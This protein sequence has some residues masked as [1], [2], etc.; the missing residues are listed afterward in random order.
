MSAVVCGAV[1]CASTVWFGNITYRTHSMFV[2]ISG[3][4]ELYPV[5]NFLKKEVACW[6]LL[7][8]RPFDV[9]RNAISE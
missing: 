3:D 1:M 6:L 8:K 4:N 2:H 9:A 5:L 7:K